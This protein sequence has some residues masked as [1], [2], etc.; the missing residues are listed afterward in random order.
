MGPFKP[1]KEQASKL[2]GCVCV[3]G[4]KRWLE[5]CPVPRGG[6]AA[7]ISQKW[8]RVL[9]EKETRGKI[10]GILTANLQGVSKS[11]KPVPK[12]PFEAF[13]VARFGLQR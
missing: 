2:A 13:K 7:G 6:V 8:G 3:V 9:E 12:K 1:S 10:Y 11:A 4:P 5:G